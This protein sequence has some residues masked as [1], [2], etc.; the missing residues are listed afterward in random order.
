MSEKAINHQKLPTAFIERESLREKGQFWTPDWIAEPMV[1]YTLSNGSNSIFDPAVGEGAFFRAA[2][3]V[4]SIL[5]RELTLLGTELD[6]DVI[7]EARKNGLS[8]EDLSKV[9]ITNFIT[10]PPLE[11]FKSIVAN[12]PY[13][14]HHRMPK[15]QKQ[16]LKELSKEIIGQT[17]DGRA[18]LHVYF[19]ILALRILEPGGKL[20]FIM[21]SD[22]CE[23][24]FAATLWKW[25]TDNY[26]LEAALT[27]GADSS[28][29]PGVDTNPI[30]FFIKNDKP[31][32]NLYWAKCDRPCKDDLLTWVKSGFYKSSSS[33]Q[34]YQRKVS[35]GISTGL[36]RKPMS[37][38]LNGPPLLQFA[39]V[40]RGIATGFN[41]Y[42]LFTRDRAKEVGI[43]EEFLRPT[44]ARTRDVPGEEITAQ[45]MQE[46]DD[47]NRPTLLLSLDGRH[48]EEFPKAVQNY[49]RI[50][51]ELKLHEKSLI[52][53]RNP[54]YKM[55]ARKV[56]P[57]LFAY[58]GRR[59]TRFIKN[60]VGTLPLTGFLCVYPRDESPEGIDKLMNILNTQDAFKNLKWVAKSYGSGAIKVEP[61]ALERLQLPLYL[62]KSEG[63]ST[64]LVF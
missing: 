44:I 63:L 60:S 37:D 53:T 5:G 6:E 19:L 62:I 34:V 15:K 50:G 57:I 23:G 32:E 20:A 51:I 54:W 61:R 13:I 29:F 43:P 9:K 7:I 26:F 41:E 10:T 8:S 28:P 14:R 3:K 18:G 17:I 35:E 58:L 21:P 56:P 4:A 39:T 30:V 64:R 45:L 40:M 52:S 24:I 12:P 46:L 47:N 38:S 33:I 22:T 42:F 2:K 59:N 27:F 16:F 1:A 25:I 49:L 31:K 48:I 36:S 11:N 55:E